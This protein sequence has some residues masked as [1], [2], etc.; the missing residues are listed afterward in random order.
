M[1]GQIAQGEEEDTTFMS[2]DSSLLEA[3]A[4]GDHLG[5]SLDSLGRK[6][7]REG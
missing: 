5:S 2:S 6:V 4:T 1:G 3:V 7:I